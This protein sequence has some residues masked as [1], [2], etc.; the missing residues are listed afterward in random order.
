M[1]LFKHFQLAMPIVWARLGLLR[2]GK[3]QI[4]ADEQRKRT[5]Q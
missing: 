4:R 1:K 5:V 2:L 3:P